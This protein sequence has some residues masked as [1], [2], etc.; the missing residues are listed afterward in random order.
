[1]IA[2]KNGDIDSVELLIQNKANVHER[3]ILGDTPLKLA[4]AHG[5]ETLSILLISKY[6]ALLRPQSNRGIVKTNIVSI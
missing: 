5:H 1:M 6:G 3:T 2:C 4:Q